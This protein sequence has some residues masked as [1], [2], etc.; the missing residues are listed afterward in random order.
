MGGSFV[1]HLRALPD[2]ELAA[3]IR[4]RPDLIVP[5][6]ADISALGVRAYS[7]L[8]VARAVDSLDR[9]TLEILDGLR[10]L[11]AD[12][13]AEVASVDELLAMMSPLPTGVE[14][15][16]VRTTVDRLRALSLVYG[17]NSALRLVS[18]LEEVCGPYPAGLGR[19]AAQLGSDVA[20]L[21]ADPARLRRELL[22]APPAATA[23]VER[24]AGGPPV[25]TMR[26]RD[27][28]ADS[29]V[30]WLTSHHVL[31]AISDEAVEL[32]R[33][34]AILLRRRQPDAAGPLGVLHPAPPPLAGVERP[35]A[36]VD[37][38]G[39]GQAMEVVRQVDEL[40]AAMS[41]EPPP[42]L[43]SGGLGVRDL[44]RLA[45]TVDLDEQTAGLL[46]EVASAAGL[47]GQV[48]GETNGPDARFLPTVSY[49]S[50]R[51]GSLA[52]RWEQ[53]IRAWVAMPREPALIGT[54]DDRDRLTGA[55]APEIERASAAVRRGGTLSVLAA[56]PPGL[57]MDADA[58]RQQ[59]SWR[60]PRRSAEAADPARWTL[61]E[62]AMLG[63]TGLGALTSFGRLLLAEAQL[64]AQRDPDAD[65]LGVGT[66][67]VADSVQ[68]LDALLP[69][70]VDHILVQADL[71]IVVP[72]P[73]AATLAAELSLVAE[74][75]SAGGASVY[76]LTPAGVR[77]ALDAGYSAADVHALFARRSKTPVPQSL[78]YLVDDV[79]RRHGGL[80]LGIAGCYLR[81]DDE[82]L[83]GEVVSD[84][85][86]AALSLRRLA[87]TVLISPYASVRVLPALREAGYAPVA[88][89]S[90]GAMVLTRRKTRRAS[91]RPSTRVAVSTVD[92]RAQLSAPRLAGIVEH[93]RRGDALARSARR[94]PASVRTASHSGPGASQA[95]SQA[96]AVLQHAVR[97]KQRVWVG[98]VDAHGATASRLVRP[99]SIGAGYLRAE[100]DR[101][102]TLHTFALHRI[103]AAELA[104][105][106]S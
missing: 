54:R 91:S 68:A 12:S 89:D 51:G 37:Q 44:R 61:A 8:S 26:T 87:P 76:R 79:A 86:V 41:E 104:D 70:P 83:L 106:A 78:T 60:T 49:D 24:L 17:P 71:T 45:R 63:L 58:V 69:D 50:W 80:R 75:E 36:A 40:L 65:P 23:I 33:E 77:R 39:A 62:S 16:S 11:A 22:A 66:D 46:L 84:K 82:T 5:V 74:H 94:A 3:L 73:P 38:A 2:A 1:D 102:E 48:D 30:A 90:T 97:G 52:Q 88:E 92:S 99:V 56:A 105:S 19:T 100:D 13:E 27:E 72:G 18:S 57:A 34:I 20:A 98:Y 9:F 103:T 14:A 28:S 7:R 85:R 53:L 42:A 6:P 35:P 29:P 31:A 4:L 64:D 47:L 55:L 21:V 32:P 81:S 15:T 10:L 25:G 59:L 67:P 95:H 101:T 93:L 96:L 43:R